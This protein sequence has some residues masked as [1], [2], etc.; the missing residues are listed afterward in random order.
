M[1]FVIVIGVELIGTI[2]GIW[3]DPSI[4]VFEHKQNYL[5]ILL[6]GGFALSSQVFRDMNRTL[7]KINYLMMPVSAFEKLLCMWLLSSIGWI[8]F[9]SLTFFVFTL[10]VKPIGNL[11]FNIVSFAPFDPFGD[12]QMASIK[13]YLV[14]HGV[15]VVGASHFKGYVF[16]KTAF[17]VFAILFTAMAL[18]YFLMVDIFGKEHECTGYDCELLILMS[19]HS[20]WAIAKFFFWWLFAPV[21][22]VTAYLG[23]KDQE[24]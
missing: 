2:L 6:L 10:L 13:S 4:V 8:L 14:L 7:S 24:V 17:T 3:T 20:I 5:F 19:E 16:P 21:C 22:W 12:F 18:M 15:F 9:Y 23:L 1:I 11:L